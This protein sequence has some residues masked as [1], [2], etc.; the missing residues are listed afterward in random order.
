MDLYPLVTS[1]PL[2]DAYQNLPQNSLLW[3]QRYSFLCSLPELLTS[4]ALGMRGLVSVSG[5]DALG[6]LEIVL[7]T[8]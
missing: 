1:S 2:D 3:D 4:Q 5:S 8:L 7:E 6:F